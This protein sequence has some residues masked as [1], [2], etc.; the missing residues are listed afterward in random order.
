VKGTL[1]RATDAGM[2][3]TRMLQFV[4]RD[5]FAAVHESLADAVDGSSTGT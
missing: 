4:F 2:G 5:F 3:T 1:S